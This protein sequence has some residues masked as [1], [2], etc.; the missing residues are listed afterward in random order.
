MSEESLQR[1]S[2]RVLF[3]ARDLL[4]FMWCFAIP[5]KIVVLS[6]TNLFKDFFWGISYLSFQFSFIEVNVKIVLEDKFSIKAGDD[7]SQFPLSGSIWSSGLVG[8]FFA[9]YQLYTLQRISYMHARF[10]Y[11]EAQNRLI[12]LLSWISNR[13]GEVEE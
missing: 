3:V 12:M 8:K 5:G 9:A 4:L 11:S 2:S 7:S 10:V 6:I 1:I 13:L